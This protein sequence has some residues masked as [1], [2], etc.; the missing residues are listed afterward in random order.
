MAVLLKGISFLRIVEKVERHKLNDCYH[1]ELFS[2]AELSRQAMFYVGK[3]RWTK[4][5]LKEFG[6]A[7]LSLHNISYQTLAIRL[8]RAFLIKLGPLLQ[9]SQ[10]L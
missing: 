9:F 1:P 4:Q 7:N 5:T 6:A 10:A 3:G 2:L 8:V